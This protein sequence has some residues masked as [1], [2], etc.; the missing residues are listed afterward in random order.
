MR[1]E[2][3]RTDDIVKCVYDGELPYN[4]AISV[5][6]GTEVV[7][8]KDGNVA[9]VV[10]EGVSEI[11][12]AGALKAVFGKCK[13][14]QQLYSVNRGKQFIVLWGTGGIGYRDKKGELKK[15]GANGSYRFAVDNSSALLR[16][17]GYPEIITES[18]V[19]EQLKGIVT[20]AVKEAVVAAIDKDGYNVGGRTGA[21]QKKAQEKLEK[22]FADYG[23]FLDALLIEEV[24]DTYGETGNE[25]E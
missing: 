4:T 13:V 10:G 17:F 18:D 24:T 9:A 14:K 22:I 16:R 2:I 21:V 11:N 20:G 12:S 6:P 23:L 7:Y 15:A 25:E 19:K 3:E 5:S 1:L 8:V